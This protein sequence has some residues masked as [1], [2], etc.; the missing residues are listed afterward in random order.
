MNEW[1]GN[2]DHENNIMKQSM[3]EGDAI[4]RVFVDVCL[5][6]RN[7]TRNSTH[8]HSVLSVVHYVL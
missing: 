2:Q 1:M 8:G 6:I 7:G 4:A 3:S 5:C